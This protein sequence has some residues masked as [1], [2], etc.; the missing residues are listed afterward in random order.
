MLSLYSTKVWFLCK[1]PGITWGQEAWKIANFENMKISSC[2]IWC[3]VCALPSCEFELNC[4]CSSQSKFQ[5]LSCKPKSCMFLEHNCQVFIAKCQIFI[6]ICCWNPTIANKVL[7]FFIFMGFI[8][9][10]SLW[11]LIFVC[12]LFC[13]MLLVS[14]MLDNNLVVHNRMDAH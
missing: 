3:V 7:T 4:C 10:D 2:K 13:V 11:S 12:M 1:Y 6:V 8:P 14:I 5:W 9:K